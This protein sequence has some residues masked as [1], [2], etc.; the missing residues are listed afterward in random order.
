MRQA[1]LTAKHDG[2]PLVQGERVQSVR[3]IVSQTGI[4]RLR[5]VFH[6]QLLLIQTHHLFAAASIF[7]KT[8]VRNPVQ[9]RRKS[10]LAAET[11]DIFIGAKKSF[12]SQIIRQSQIGARELP[13]Q[14]THAGLMPAHKFRKSVV[15]VIDKNA[16]DEIG[17]SE[18]HNRD[19]MALAEAEERPFC[20][21][22]SIL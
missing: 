1:V 11:A 9:P 10:R 6:L 3:Q 13:Q 20:L 21:P 12:L 16:R 17:I 15:I 8:V 7:A 19:S 2:R 22:I 18:L 14:P 4:N 5:V